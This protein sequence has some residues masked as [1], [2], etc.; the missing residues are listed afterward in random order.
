MNINF[1][2]CFIM[3]ELMSNISKSTLKFFKE[4]ITGENTAFIPVFRD[5][6]V[7]IE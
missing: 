4:N 3:L 6:K 1:I 2:F 7:I 5:V